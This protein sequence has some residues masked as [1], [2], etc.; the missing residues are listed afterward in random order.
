[1]AGDPSPGTQAAILGYPLDG[2]FKA[3]PGRLGQTETVDTQNAYG[4]GHVLRTITAL[5]GRVRPG[6]SGGPMVDGRGEVVATV[7][8][9]LT[10]T[11][12]PG[13][14]AVPDRVVRAELARAVGQ[15]GPV[16][17][18]ACAN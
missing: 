9:A 17:T 14:F 8:A 3:E 15:T 13:G 2:P 10:G 11:A 12:H 16:A 1:M 7:F 5:R 6:N 4:Q 18:G